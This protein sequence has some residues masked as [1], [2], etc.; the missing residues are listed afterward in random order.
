MRFALVIVLLVLVLAIIGCSKS[1]VLTGSTIAN[2]K[3]PAQTAQATTPIADA[4]SDDKPA[5]ADSDDPQ[6]SQ[7]LLGDDITPPDYSDKA[8]TCEV[9]SRGDIRVIDETGKKTI[10]R[11][12][13]LGGTVVEYTCDGNK[14]VTKLVS[15]PKGC[16]IENYVG[17]CA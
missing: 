6:E 8:G 17:K 11:D 3:A 13:C 5:A 7:T 10:Y 14:L 12:D 9:T 2:T 1:S 16:T 4:S 15:C